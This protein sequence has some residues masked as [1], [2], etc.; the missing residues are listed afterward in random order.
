M[1]TLPYAGWPHYPSPPPR[2]IFCLN[3]SKAKRI[4]YKTG[5]WEA[6]RKDVLDSSHPSASRPL[7]VAVNP[8]VRVS[9]DDAQ[10]SLSETCTMLLTWFLGLV[11]ADLPSQFP[12]LRLRFF[13]TPQRQST[14]IFLFWRVCYFKKS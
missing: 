1:A 4:K 13:P 6:Y 2:N 10:M 5:A 7:T 11:S 14:H 9:S 12:S 3:S 8:I